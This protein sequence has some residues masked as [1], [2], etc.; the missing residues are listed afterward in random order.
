MERLDRVIILNETEELS[1][2]NIHKGYRGFL[3]EYISAS[4]E[5]VVCILDNYNDGAYAVVKVAEKDLEPGNPA[6][7]DLKK[8]WERIIAKPDFYTHMELRKP[9]FQEYDKVMLMV[10]KPKYAKAGL[11]K[12]DI[13]CVMFPYAVL[14]DWGVYFAVEGA[15]EDIYC[16]VDMDDMEVVD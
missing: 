3:V 14:N 7:D 5:W 13:G 11:K 12:G 4:K 9:K 15:D 2:K 16:D 8:I 10:D 1:K 6:T